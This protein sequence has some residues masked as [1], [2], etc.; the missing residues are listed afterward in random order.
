MT[1]PLPPRVKDFLATLH[2]GDACSGEVASIHQ[3]G[4]LV[5]LDGAPEPSMGHIPPSEV[6]WK[7]LSSC[8]E[9]VTVGQRVTGQ[10]LGVDAEMRGQVTLS[11]I[12]QQ[13]NPWLAWTGRVGSVFSGRVTRVVP[14]GVFVG[15]DEGMDGLVHNSELSQQGSEQALRVGD[16]MAVQIS[17]VDPLRRLIRL[18]LPPQDPC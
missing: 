17:E 14:F 4:V 3:F 8:G 7:W 5:N 9:A 11:L 15:V 12:A 18:S 13:P 6:S 2:R 10:V 1:Y 16:E